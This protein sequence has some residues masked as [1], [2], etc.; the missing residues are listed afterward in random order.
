[1]QIDIINITQKLLDKLK[2]CRKLFLSTISGMQLRADP[3]RLQTATCTCSADNACYWLNLSRRRI[4]DPI[5]DGHK[6]EKCCKIYRS[7][8][9]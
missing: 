6:D 2:A 9:Q 8:M 1:M 4:W 7:T 5:D 3:I